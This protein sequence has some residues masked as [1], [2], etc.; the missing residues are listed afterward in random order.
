MND[1]NNDQNQSLPIAFKPFFWD[2][3]FSSLDIEKSKRTI[4]VKLL[5]YGSMEHW[6][7]LNDHYG[8]EVIREVMTNVPVTEIRKPTAHLAQLLFDI[9]LN[10]APRGTH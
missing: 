3:V 5:S 6:R 2:T 1:H 8:K 10:Y 9:K 4:I 7:W